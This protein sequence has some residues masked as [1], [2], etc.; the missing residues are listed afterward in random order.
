[1]QD[2][3]SHPS[4]N[5]KRETLALRSYSFITYSTQALVVSFLPLF[6]L[7]KGYNASQIGFL[8]L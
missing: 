1:M 5:A 4:H 6:F 8:Y 2:S 7:D 3:V